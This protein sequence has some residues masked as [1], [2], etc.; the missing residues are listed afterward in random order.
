MD[1]FIQRFYTKNR[2]IRLEEEIKEDHKIR[3]QEEKNI[4]ER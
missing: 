2:M 1:S 3:L 4:K